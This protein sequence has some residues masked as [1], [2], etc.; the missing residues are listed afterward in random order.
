MSSELCKNNIYSLME[1]YNVRVWKRA[2]MLAVT[3]LMPLRRS[4]SLSLSVDMAGCVKLFMFMR[5]HAF[6]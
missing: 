3:F 6:F 4:V 2:D 1:T 5:K